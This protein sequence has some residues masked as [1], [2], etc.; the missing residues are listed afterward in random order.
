MIWLLAAFPTAPA[1]LFSFLFLGYVRAF[2]SSPCIYCSF[3]ISWHLFKIFVITW[4]VI[5]SGALAV[6]SSS[7]TSPE[8]YF[9]C[10]DFLV[11][12]SLQ[13]LSLALSFVIQFCPISP[14]LFVCPGDLFCVGLNSWSSLGISL[15]LFYLYLCSFSSLMTC[16][17]LRL[18]TWLLRVQKLASWKRDWSG[19]CIAFS[20]LDLEA[21]LL[22]SIGWSSHRPT[23]VQ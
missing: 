11:F 3:Q 10:F 2:Y 22:R 6:Y 9:L 13:Y 20:D 17:W 19:S 14:P 16:E 23:Q 7:F 12:H 18:P 4:G 5:F 1:V 15:S 8:S 21:M